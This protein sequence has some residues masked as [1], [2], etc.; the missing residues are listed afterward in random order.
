MSGNW[1]QSTP[2]DVNNSLGH[3]RGRE[4]ELPEIVLRAMFTGELAVIRMLISQLQ[5]SLLISA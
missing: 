5:K 3:D 4:T 2:I 1:K